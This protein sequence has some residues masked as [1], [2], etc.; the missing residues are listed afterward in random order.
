MSFLFNTPSCHSFSSK[1]QVYSNFVTELTICGDFGTQE[2]KI[3]YCFHIF[4][5]Y[6]LRSDGTGCHDVSVLN[7]VLKPAF[8]LSSFTLIKRLFN[9]FL[10]SVIR[11]VSSAYLRLLLFLLAILIPACESSSLE[12]CMMYSA[13][14][15]NKQGH[16]IQ[17]WCTPFPILNQF[18]VPCKI[19]TL[20]SRPAYRLLRR[21]LRWSGIPISLRIFH[22]LLWSSQPMN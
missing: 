14:K 16:N 1:K 3:C 15:L 8:S 2:K 21:Q 10:L 17:P 20:S 18:I 12:F 11:V 7:V 6:L 4:P 5:L 13:C 9:S 22:S 19:L